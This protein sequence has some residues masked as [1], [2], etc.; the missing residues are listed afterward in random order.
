MYV[1]NP[2]KNRTVVYVTPLSFRRYL[3]LRNKNVVKAAIMIPKAIDPNIMIRKLSK[4]FKGVY[5]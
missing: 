2:N 5:Q 1:V 4:T 3:D